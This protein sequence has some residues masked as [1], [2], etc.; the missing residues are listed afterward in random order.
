MGVRHVDRRTFVAGVDDADAEP[1]RMVPDRLDVAA[2][3]PEDAVDAARLQ[4][5]RDPGR[6]GVGVG[7]EVLR[8]AC[9]HG[10]P[11]CPPDSR[12]LRS[13]CWIFPVAVR[14]TS[15]SRRKLNERGRL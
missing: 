13:R 11:P 14:G 12:A 2:L 9:C 10:Q 4:E 5:T 6:T 7:V 1:R 15:S 8:F 3:E